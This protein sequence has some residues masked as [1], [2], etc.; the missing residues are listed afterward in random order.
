MRWRSSSTGRSSTGSSASATGYPH[1]R[2]W[3]WVDDGS[4]PCPDWAVPYEVAA[5]S[6]TARVA[7]PWGRSGDDLL[8]IY[9]GG[10]TGMPKGVMWRQDDLF[11][12][13]INGGSR[14]YPVDGGIEA[15]R[16]S[17]TADDRATTLL[18]ACPLM[19]GTGWFTTNLCLAEGGRVVLLAE[20]PVRPGRA[21]RHARAREGERPR[22]RRRPFLPPALSMR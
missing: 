2:A 15:V 8:M 18:P 5:K 11:V 19:H 10:T 21:A 22:H 16:E 13:L 12:R 20:P 4:G 17:L 7:A 9:T 6:A 3:L 1:V 14:Q